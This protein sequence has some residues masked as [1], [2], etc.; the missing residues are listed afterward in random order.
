MKQRYLKKTEEPE[1][2]REGGIQTKFLLFFPTRLEESGNSNRDESSES[3][4]G[5]VTPGRVSSGAARGLSVRTRRR[6]GRRD[7][8]GLGRRVGRGGLRSRRS[9]RR[10]RLRVRLGVREHVRDQVDNSVRDRDLRERN[11]DRSDTFLSP[12]EI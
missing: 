3:T 12:S 11:P 9:G 8:S 6:V 4:D 2:E 5:D 7:A 10:R 1:R